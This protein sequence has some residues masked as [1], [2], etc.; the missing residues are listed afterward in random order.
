MGKERE[1]LR[2]IIDNLT[3]IYED[4]RE[5]LSVSSSQ[6]AAERDGDYGE[7]FYNI[8]VIYD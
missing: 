2:R 6:H 5:L 7:V 1:T 3:K 8:V 4:D